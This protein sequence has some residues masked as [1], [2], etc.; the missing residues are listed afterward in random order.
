MEMDVLA[1]GKTFFL[2]KQV[3]PQDDQRPRGQAESMQIASSCISWI[4]FSA[5]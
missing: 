1:T 3:D 4:T 2:Y 5:A